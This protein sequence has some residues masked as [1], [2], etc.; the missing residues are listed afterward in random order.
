MPLELHP[1]AIQALVTG[2][3][4]APT[5]VLGKHHVGDEVSIRTF[6]PWAKRIDLVNDDTG[7]R[8]RMKKHHDEGLFVANLD[9]TWVTAPY[10][11]EAKTD[12]SGVDTYIDPYAYPPLLSEYDIYLFGQG[13]H[14][15]IY[16][17]LGAHSRDIDGVSGI[18]FAVWAPNC[19]KVA[20]VG[21]FNRWD[22]RSHVME[23]NGESGIWELFVPGLEAG[24][25]YKYEIRS[26]NSGYWAEKSDPYG[27]YAE[28][29][30]KTASIVY[31]IDRYQWSDSEWMTARAQQNPL[32][33]PMNVYELH[34][35]S[36]KRKDDDAFLSYREL[37]D[38]LA[39]YLVEMGYTHLEL[40]PIAEHPLDASWGYQVIGYFA[41]TSRYGT[42]D[43]LMYF[44]D[45]CHQNNIAVILDW[46]PA[47][48]PKDGH[49]LNYFDGTHLYSHEDPLQGEHPD[50]GTM[51]FNYARSEVRNFL[52]ANALFWLKEY[53]IDGLRVDAVSSMIYLNFS[54]ENGAWV[55]NQ[56]GSH[57]N[58]GALAF[59]R[60][61][62]E[63]V[64]AEAPGAITIAE[65][66]TA[67][68]MVSR[69]TYV[70]GLGFTFK[71][72][73]GWMHDT[74]E[75]M[76]HD[77]VHR[78]FHHHQITFALLYAF[79][80][81]FVLPLSHDEV[82]HLKGS[83]IGKMPGDYWQKFAGLRLLFGYQYTQ[84]GKVLNFMGNEFAQFAEWSEERSLDWHLLDY[85][86]HAQM[87]AWVRDLNHL[88]RE[89]PAL[90][91]VDFEPDGFR[92]IE[93][94]DA[95]YS[96]YSYIRYAEDRSDFLIVVLNCTPEVRNNYRFGVPDAGFYREM[97]NSD[98]GFYGGGDIGN[99]GGAHSD[100]IAMHGLPQSI[101]LR[102]P[103]LGILILKL[104]NQASA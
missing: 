74:L 104:E 66:S 9:S 94:N 71:W 93:A 81:N 43:D 47:H 95:D 35:G 92:W 60:E 21:D 23:Q 27:F 102:L 14:H 80:E 29:R 91:Q 57:E 103:P 18:N 1:D 98:A 25:H 26:H 79:S 67:W 16:R 61:F 42:P 73:M 46:V 78:R 97:L 11:F 48:F 64:H 65:E 22:T 63:V 50:W 52:I 36:W 3:I 37:A 88:Y 31:D 82:V 5:S 90:W 20:L 19:Y 2:E 70:G 33:Q 99:D 101:S 77:P 10:H 8:V 54:R 6:R 85:E 7:H 49:G 89:Q 62:N 34:P 17:K 13:Q 4:G 96:V 75:Y 32:N 56:Y 30:P 76:A 24:A 38:E 87:Q 84:V 86:K 59:L 45:C 15:D 12:D 68:A 44:V 53:H 40:L 69:P 83:L 55:P 58:L 39:P 51:I 28:L 100:D 72:N 41:P